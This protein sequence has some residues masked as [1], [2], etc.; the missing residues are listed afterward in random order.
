M[1]SRK[2]GRKEGRKEGAIPNHKG[3]GG[4]CVDEKR[5]KRTT[6]TGGECECEREWV[7]QSF[8]LHT[9]KLIAMPGLFPLDFH[10]SALT[11]SCF[12]GRVQVR[13]GNERI[14]SLCTAVRTL[15]SL[16]LSAFSSMGVLSK[17]EGER[18][19]GVFV[20]VAKNKRTE[21]SFLPT[22]LANT[23]QI[24]QASRSKHLSNLKPSIPID[25]HWIHHLTN[26][27]RTTTSPAIFHKLQG[28]GTRFFL[29][30]MTSNFFGLQ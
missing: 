6:W 16:F 27:P 28:T 18:V 15:L 24:K 7:E 13:S 21:T 17:C 26:N 14:I 25:T 5:W 9:D 8:L 19:R 22:R 29:F 10:L 30:F 11:L 2:R 3:L 23:G 1:K 4:V 12:P 20:C